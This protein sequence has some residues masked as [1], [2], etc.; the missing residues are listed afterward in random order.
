VRKYQGAFAL[1]PACVA[2]EA[3]RNLQLSPEAC[4]GC[5]ARIQHLFVKICIAFKFT[6]YRRRL[7]TCK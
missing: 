1:R 3:I 7:E 2:D 5:T 6:E 4:P